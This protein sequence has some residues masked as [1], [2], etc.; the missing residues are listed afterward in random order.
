M[1]CNKPYYYIVHSIISKLLPNEELK[2]LDI[3][4]DTF[5][6]NVVM[7]SEKEKNMVYDS[8]DS[9]INVTLMMRDGN[10]F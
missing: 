9:P 4:K 6:K 10:N 2:E 1:H 8:F 7:K 3:L 5:G